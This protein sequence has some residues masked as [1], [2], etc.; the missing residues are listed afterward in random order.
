MAKLDGRPAL[1][2]KRRQRCI[3]HLF[4]LVQTLPQRQG[5]QALARSS[6]FHAVR[7]LSLPGICGF[8][9][10]LHLL[11]FDNDRDAAAAERW[12]WPK[13]RTGQSAGGEED[14]GGLSHH[15][16]QTGNSDPSE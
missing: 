12:K 6:G 5:F 3:E 1:T 14:G 11:R 4:S 15:L 16:F 2:G 10:P 8:C 9:G 13:D 7:Q